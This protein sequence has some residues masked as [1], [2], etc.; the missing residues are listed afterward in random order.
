MPAFSPFFGLCDTLNIH[1]ELDRVEVLKKPVKAVFHL[2]LTAPPS[3]TAQQH[4]TWAA[5]YPE[6]SSDRTNGGTPQILHPELSMVS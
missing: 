6:M 2:Q 4:S 5:F 3:A 1:T